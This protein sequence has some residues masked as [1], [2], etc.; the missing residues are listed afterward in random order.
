[1][2]DSITSLTDTLTEVTDPQT[3][4]RNLRALFFKPLSHRARCLGKIFFQQPQTQRPTAQ[5]EEGAVRERRG[6]TPVNT[7]A[8]KNGEQ[9][10]FG[11]GTARF[12]GSVASLNKTSLSAFIFLF[13]LLVCLSP[14]FLRTLSAA[15]QSSCLPRRNDLHLRERRRRRRGFS[16]KTPVFDD[17]SPTTSRRVQVP[18]AVLPTVKFTRLYRIASQ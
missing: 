4:T 7:P 8:K 12:A 9:K 14:R 1:M 10:I 16:S 2:R 3:Q 6:G 18:T 11:K 13:L 15:G 5:G 17:F